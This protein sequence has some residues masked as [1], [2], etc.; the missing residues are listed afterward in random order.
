MFAL[1][2]ISFTCAADSFI[3]GFP[4]DQ[5]ANYQDMPHS[6]VVRV[7][8]GR[9]DMAEIACFQRKI[10]KGESLEDGLFFG[11]GPL[12]EHGRCP[13]F[14]AA[15][16]VTVG[17]TARVKNLGPITFNWYRRYIP[18][19]AYWH[20]LRAHDL[21]GY[22]HFQFADHQYDYA[23]YDTDDTLTHYLIY[24]SWY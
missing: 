13:N 1:L 14:A 6:V 11:V 23:L 12:L 4:A 20:S 9:E 3:T 7:R 5:L 17:S 19:N 8:K 18:R 10:A 2:P 21:A 16:P 24:Y 15:Q 22:L